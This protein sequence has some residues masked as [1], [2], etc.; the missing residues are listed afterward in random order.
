MFMALIRGG[1]HDGHVHMFPL[2]EGAPPEWLHVPDGIL[3][4][5]LLTDGRGRRIYEFE[6]MTEVRQ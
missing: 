4:L 2:K 5:S 3:R 6:S 1:P